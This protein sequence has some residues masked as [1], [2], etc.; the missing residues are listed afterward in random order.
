MYMV[1]PGQNLPRLGLPSISL[2]DQPRSILSNFDLGWD[3]RSISGR[4]SQAV[5]DPLP[6]QIIRIVSESF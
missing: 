2:Q 6:D 3:A 4:S 5:L 1:T